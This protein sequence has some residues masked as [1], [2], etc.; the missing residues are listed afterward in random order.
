[1]KFNC[2]SKYG[3][4]GLVFRENFAIEIDSDT[5]ATLIPCSSP[6]LNMKRSKLNMSNQYEHTDHTEGRMAVQPRSEAL[7]AW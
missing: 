1:M 6:P 5:W 7:E 2:G 3:H 4:W